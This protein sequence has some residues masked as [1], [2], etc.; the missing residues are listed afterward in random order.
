MRMTDTVNSKTNNCHR[1]FLFFLI[2]TTLAGCIHQPSSASQSEDGFF[3]GQSRINFFVS[4]PF[5]TTAGAEIYLDLVDEVTGLNFNPV[6]YKMQPV[7]ENLYAL[8]I[9]FPDSSLVK[10]RYAM[11]SNPTVSENNS[12]GDPVRYRVFNIQ[13]DGPA[14]VHDVIASW[15]ENPVNVSL[16]RLQ[17]KLADANTGA[18][19]PNALINLNGL[20]TRSTDTGEFRLEGALPGKYLLTIYSIDGR[21]LPF[22]QEAIIASDALTPA[23][24]TLIPR[25]A[26]Q[27]AFIVTLPQ[28]HNSQMPVRMIGRAAQLGNTFPE[29]P[30]GASIIPAN[31]P[32]L[33]P[34]A[35]GTHALTLNLPAGMDLRYKYTIGDG[36]WNAERQADGQFITRQLIVPDEDSIITDTI[37]T[38]ESGDRLPVSI[39][40]LPHPDGEI[41]PQLYIQFYS[42]TWAEPIPMW[43][44]A[45]KTKWVY[46]VYSPLY[47]FN[48]IEYRFCY[49]PQCKQMVIFN[50]AAA[51]ETFRFSTDRSQT[52][53][54]HI[55]PLQQ[56]GADESIKFPPSLTAHIPDF[57]HSFTRR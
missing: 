19:I 56:Y 40:A 26:T 13:Q 10:Y 35:D 2:I 8:E 29:D 22:Q 44:N 41:P 33:I 31:A 15:T 32:L 3:I 4:T 7:S 30:G 1:C 27:V 25:P 23:Q 48:T 57:Q 28:D 51:T 37:A 6:R 39:E 5:E 54:Q 47:L 11:G 46:K 36:F 14:I 17:G 55:L 16:G 18:P 9:D 49:D 53:I 52:P 50:D 45:E 34:Q 42:Y 38:W 21:Y 24:V 12:A 43:Q 20:Q